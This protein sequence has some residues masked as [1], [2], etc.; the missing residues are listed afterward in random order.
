MD[1]MQKPGGATTPA[2]LRLFCLGLLAVA[3]C[4]CSPGRRLAPELAAPAGFAEQRIDTAPFVLRAWL[5]DRPD[6]SPGR[7]LCVYIEGDGLA[8]LRSGPSIDPTPANPVGLRLALADPSTGPVLYLARPCQYV[9][10]EDR[11]GC[12]VE[13]WTS[14]RFSE[15]AVAALN[16]AV[17][18][19]KLRTGAG[20]V[21]LHGFSGGAAMAALIAARRDDVVFLATAAG[22]LDHALWTRLTG[23]DALAGSLNP[24]EASAVL[25]EIAQLHVL[26]GEDRVVPPALLDEWTRRGRPKNMTR[27]VL[28]GIPHEGPFTP[29]WSELL[30]LHRPP[31]Q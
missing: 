6:T 5:R 20:K 26:A 10:G 11:R 1:H 3:L 31:L 8:W 29:A 19:M 14:E 18:R 16:E 22:N 25:R 27:A 28:P 13:D 12:R 2:A 24:V 23:Y 4:A 17:S 21:A 9:E 15:R 7:A 30:R